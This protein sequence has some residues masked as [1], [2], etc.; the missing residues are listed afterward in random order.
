MKRRGTGWTIL[1]LLLIAAAFFLIFYNIREDNQAKA[2]SAAVTEQIRQYL[3]IDPPDET[4]MP[5]YLIYPEMEMP[6]Q[7]VDG[8]PYVGMLTIPAL[9]VE[10]P[11]CDEWSYPNLRI[12][13][14]R[15]TG[16]A[17]TNN[18]ILCAHNYSTHF[19]NI[20]S[21]HAGDQVLFTDMDGHVFTYEVAVLEILQ[22]TDIEEMESGD[23]DLTLFTCTLGG[24][25]RVTVR[26]INIL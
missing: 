13:P 23:W 25:S 2:S 17:Y 9:G 11:V 22:P 12:A 20:K 6:V 21:L 24:Q 8:L 19:G 18:L 7:E 14:C 5:G 26:C 16:S 10:L 4:Q 3:P 1:G 15:Y